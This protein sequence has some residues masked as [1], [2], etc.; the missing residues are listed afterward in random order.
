[1]SASKSLT[2]SEDGFAFD[3][4]TG[5]SFT[6]N[7]CGQ[8]IFAQLQQGNTRQQIAEFLAS[9]YSIAYSTAQRDLA[10]FFQ[11]LQTLGLMGV[12]P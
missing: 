10:D 8:I 7:P 4:A 9:K 11:Q 1:M 5:E 6:L 2:V 3:L 12:N